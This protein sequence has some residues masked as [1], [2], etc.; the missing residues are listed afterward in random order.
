MLTINGKSQVQYTKATVKIDM[1]KPFKSPSGFC[2][3]TERTIETNE[4]DRRAKISSLAIKNITGYVVFNKD[5]EDKTKAAVS[6]PASSNPV[7]ISFMDCYNIGYNEECTRVG[8]PLPK[9]FVSRDV[10]NPKKPGENYP[11]STFIQ[12]KLGPDFPCCY[13]KIVC[14]EDGTLKNIISN[15]E[16]DEGSELSTIRDYI[17]EALKN[18]DTDGINL[19]SEVYGVNIEITDKQKKTF[20]VSGKPKTNFKLLEP[21]NF[22]D[23]MKDYNVTDIYAKMKPTYV[24]EGAKTFATIVANKVI[25]ARRIASNQEIEDDFERYTKELCGNSRVTE[26]EAIDPN[27]IDLS[28]LE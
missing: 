6:I 3:N 1:S 26:V 16:F 10:P 15:V 23:I 7:V 25:C 17:R 28:N 24:R 8:L 2:Y 4:G 21:S 5:S 14:V 12:I 9:P 27:E 18:N 20:K 19:I 13:T 11:D 22:S